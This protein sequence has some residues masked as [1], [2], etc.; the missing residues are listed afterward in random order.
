MDLESTFTC[1]CTGVKAGCTDNDFAFEGELKDSQTNGQWS[2][3]TSSIA[4]TATAT[5]TADNK[6]QM[7]VTCG[8]GDQTVSS[9]FTVIECKN[10]PKFLFCFQQ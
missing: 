5:L 7:T 4:H 9:T 2:D 3:V 8:S 6:G 10:E 1:T